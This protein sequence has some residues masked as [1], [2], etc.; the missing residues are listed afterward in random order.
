MCI[1]LLRIDTPTWAETAQ[2]K[3]PKRKTTL[4]ASRK[5]T[6]MNS[7]IT[8]LSDAAGLQHS[9]MNELKYTMKVDFY[10]LVLDSVTV[11]FES[12]FNAQS[13]TVV[14]NISAMLKADDSFDGAVTPST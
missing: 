3:Q 11:S 5:D 8:R 4:P 6:V 14:K 13:L 9:E 12:Q 2:N 10:L 7:F 1:L